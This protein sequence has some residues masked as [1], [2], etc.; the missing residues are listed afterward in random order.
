MVTSTHDFMVLVK[1]WL[2]AMER[3]LQS[4]LVARPTSSRWDIGWDPTP[5]HGQVVGDAG[6]RRG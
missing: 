1:V 5:V 3:F 2:L 6:N 4:D